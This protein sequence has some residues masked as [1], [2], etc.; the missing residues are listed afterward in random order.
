MNE[1]ADPLC[2][3]LINLSGPRWR[4]LRT[5]LSPAFT[6]GKIRQMFTLIEECSIKYKV[7]TK[8]H[9]PYLFFGSLKLTVDFIDL[10]LLLLKEYVRKHADREETVEFRDLAAKFTTEVISTCCFGLETNTIQD[11]DS[12]F[13]SMCR[14]VLDPSL[15][16]SLKRIV[17][18][19]LPGVF[20]WF[21]MSL[22]PS[23]VFFKISK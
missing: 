2:V 9:S 8:I 16:I 21:R 10:I 1:S 14:K 11:E 6:A 5:K 22:T 23:E 4:I 13:R 7:N 18:S 19:Y 3:N 20:Q 17:R 15:V 12:E